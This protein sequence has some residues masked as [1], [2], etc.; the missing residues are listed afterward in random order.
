MI[1]T[2]MRRVGMESTDVKRFIYKMAL[3]LLH[4]AMQYLSA[5][6]ER[7]QSRTQHIFVAAACLSKTDGARGG[8]NAF[9]TNFVF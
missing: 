6:C 7:Q 8:E 1:S 5:I 3:K 2:K 9:T 4:S